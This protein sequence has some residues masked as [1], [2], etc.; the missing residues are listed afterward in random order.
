[1]VSIYSSL[2]R[3]VFSAPGILQTEGLNSERALVG[4]VPAGCLGCLGN[5]GGS[6][7]HKPILHTHTSNYLSVRY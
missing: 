4:N 5:Y 3:S 2:K 1:M 6:C 7:D